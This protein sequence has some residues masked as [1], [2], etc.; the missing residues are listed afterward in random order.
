MSGGLGT[1]PYEQNMLG[2]NQ[3]ISTDNAAST[4]T[5]STRTACTSTTKSSSS[6]MSILY[7]S[8]HFVAGK[9]GMGTTEFGVSGGGSAA[10]VACRTKRSVPGESRLSPVA[11]TSTPTTLTDIHCPYLSNPPPPSVHPIKLL[12]LQPPAQGRPP[13]RPHQLDRQPRAQAPRGPWPH[14]RGQ[15]EPRS[16]Q[17]LQAQPPAWTCQLEEAQHVSTMF[18]DLGLAREWDGDGC[19]VD[20]AG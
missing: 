7:F 6:S 2:Q 11:A 19:G 10:M 13:R 8:V 14:R 18:G 15:K 1:W 9:C 12:T 20:L 4:L 5:G 16:R 17:G 3:S